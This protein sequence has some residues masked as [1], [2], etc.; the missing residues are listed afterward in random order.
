M[1]NAN[2]IYRKVGV[3]LFIYI[4]LRENRGTIE[5]KIFWIC[6]D[7]MADF[8]IFSVYIE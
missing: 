5:V 6:I 3:I 1:K 2:D 8:Y 7:K 4:K